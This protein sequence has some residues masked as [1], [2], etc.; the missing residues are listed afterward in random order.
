MNDKK[1]LVYIILTIIILLLVA[2]N[3]QIFISHNF[4]EENNVSEENIITN[5]IYNTTS[6]EEDFNNRKNKIASLTER[7]RMQTYF[8]EYISAIENKDYEK[9]YSLLY[10]N[11]KNNYFPTLLDFANYAEAKYPKNTRNK[12]G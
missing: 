10:D 5:K 2:I 6:E 12:R 11:F 9:A 7:Q 3:I 8:G 4:K 1:K